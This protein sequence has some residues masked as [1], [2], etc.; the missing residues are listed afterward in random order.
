MSEIFHK[1][2]EPFPKESIR[3]RAQ[4][5]S[6][7]KALA[8]AYIDARDVMSRLDSVVGPA[9]WQSEHFAVGG[10]TGC[11]IG[12]YVANG[13]HGQWVW[14]SD[15]AGDTDIEGAKGAFSTAFKRASTSWGIGRYLYDLGATW[16]PCET[17][18]GKFKKFIG[19]PWQYVKSPPKHLKP[20]DG[21]HGPLG[22]TALK[23][24]LMAL[25]GDL[26]G[27]KD[28]E[29]VEGLVLDNKE[30]IEQCERDLKDWY[31]G[32]DQARGL[33]DNIEQKRLEY[34]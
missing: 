2:S 21:W 3:W 25:A 26:A 34:S 12:I 14:K 22:I 13:Q 17:K 6:G 16:V 1:L 32:N 33:K 31:Y 20:S 7:D 24:A 11:R 28:I 9:G 8:L 19:D 5:V 15:G 4:M 27:V 30:L 18:D 10:K 23:E 29:D